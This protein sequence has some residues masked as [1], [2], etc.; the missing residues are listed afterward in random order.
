MCAMTDQSK[1]ADAIKQA[2]EYEALKRAVMR[3]LDDPQVQQ[4]MRQL[5]Q[6]PRPVRQ[7]MAH[8]RSR[9]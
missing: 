7:E 5:F 6:G 8:G 3:L 1:P 9:L 2:E 4:K